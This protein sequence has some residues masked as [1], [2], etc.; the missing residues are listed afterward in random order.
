M[1]VLKVDINQLNST[2]KQLGSLS[3]LNGL[4]D[5]ASAA[6]SQLNLADKS[7][8]KAAGDAAAGI[9]SI[10]DFDLDDGLAKAGDALAEI[11]GDVPGLE[12]DLAPVVESVDA[13]AMKAITG[14]AAAV[15]QA[16]LN[17]IVAAGSPQAVAEALQT[18]LP[19]VETRKITE[20]LSDLADVADLTALD[21]LEDAL[22][23]GIAAASGFV[24]GITKALGSVDNLL[25]NITNDLLA[26]LTLK[27]DRTVFN[28][29]NDTID[30]NKLDGSIDIYEAINLIHKRDWDT[31]INSVPLE[32]NKLYREGMTADEIVAIT[33]DFQT[34]ITGLDLDP[35]KVITDNNK[36]ADIADKAIPCFVIGSNDNE[37]KGESTPINSSVFTVVDSYDELVAEFRHTPREITEFVAHWT[38]TYNNQDIGAEEVHQWHLDRGWSGCGYHYIIRRD[39]RLQRGRPLSK[40][41]A[42]AGDNGHNKY[43]IGISFAGGYNCS[44]GTRNASKFISAESLTSQQFKTFEMFCKAFYDVWPDGQAFG[45]VDTDN[46]GK[47]DPGFSVQDYVYEKFGKVNVNKSGR[48]APLS[49]TQIATAR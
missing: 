7:I 41:G 6:T 46:K 2:V 20:G 19:N 39:G 36:S 22:S 5:I 21:N 16:P 37:W 30:F 33:K 34:K 17:K 47:V 48:V 13:E 31:L 8:F 18:V 32:A 42:H 27:L 35:A 23:G 26:D 3:A 24:D 11:S 4:T 10:A 15:T 25:E 9:K 44:S 38:G 40:Q 1:T 28:T 43:S 45:H 12:E 29:L 49:S 14:A